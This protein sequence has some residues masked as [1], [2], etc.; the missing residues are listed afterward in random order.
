M[1]KN[2]SFRTGLGYGWRTNYNQRVYVWEKD[3]DFYI[4]EDEDGTDHY[5]EKQCRGMAQGT[6]LCV[7]N[8]ALIW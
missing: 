5:F 6:V 7:D 3:S 8:S 4:W 1:G 2:V